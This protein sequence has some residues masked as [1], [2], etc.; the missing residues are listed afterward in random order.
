MAP[1][2]DVYQAGTLSGNPMAMAA[3]M[4]T[5]KRL[6]SKDLFQELERKGALLFSG[7]QKAAANSKIAVAVNRVG[8]MGTVFFA[9]KPVKDFETAKKSNQEIFRQFYRRMLEQGIYLAP[10]QFEATFLSTSH[11]EEVIA[12][13]V[14]CA[15][16]AFDSIQGS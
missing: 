15:A 12:K 4:A 1:E 16:K 6:K 13:T 14:D 11:N 8:S 7:L 5:L 2:G 9:D 3:G 10:S